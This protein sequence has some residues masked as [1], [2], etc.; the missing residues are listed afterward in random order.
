M[1]LIKATAPNDAMTLWF[2]IEDCPG[3]GESRRWAAAHAMKP[4]TETTNRMRYFATVSVCALALHI[5]VH[6]ADSMKRLEPQMDALQTAAGVYD[7]QFIEVPVNAPVASCEI[8]VEG[9]RSRKVVFNGKSP[10]SGTPSIKSNPPETVKLVTVCVCLRAQE[11]V[12][13][14][15]SEENQRMR[16][17][18]GTGSTRLGYSF[19]MIMEN[20]K[21]GTGGHA[22]VPHADFDFQEMRGAMKCDGAAFTIVGR[23]HSTHAVPI[24]VYF[25]KKF[26]VTSLKGEVDALDLPDG[27]VV[28]YAAIK[29][30]A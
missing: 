3:I 19:T 14:R 2:Q 27:T 9:Y 21:S 22:V 15:R 23:H 28:V 11:P 24:L 18:P 20:G 4:S 10:G 13:Y 30:A 16:R 7:A 25:P 5:P 17:V 8:V 26:D 29:K 1:S 6:G 12:E